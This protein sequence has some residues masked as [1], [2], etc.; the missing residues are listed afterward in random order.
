[1]NIA[2]HDC[3]PFAQKA[4]SRVTPVATHLAECLNAS[5]NNNWR[6]LLLEANLHLMLWYGPAEY[7]QVVRNN[8]A[9]LPPSLVRLDL[10]TIERK[11]RR[12]LELKPDSLEVYGSLVTALIFA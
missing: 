11:L 3:C 8:A 12:A 1:M 7:Q 10:P 6:V 4:L 5:P 9:R 2:I